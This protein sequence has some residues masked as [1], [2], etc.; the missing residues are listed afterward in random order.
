[1]SFF[2][3]TPTS[4]TGI[5][6]SWHIASFPLKAGNKMEHMNSSPF[7]YSLYNILV[8]DTVHTEVNVWI[9]GTQRLH[10]NRN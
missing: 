1:M 2:L 9:F 4:F 3:L 7:I 10:S 6:N 5:Y 8:C